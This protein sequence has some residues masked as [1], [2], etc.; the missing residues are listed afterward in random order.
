MT[1][2][3]IVVLS[4]NTKSL[5]VRCIRSIA[6]VYKNLIGKELEV[7]LTDNGSTDQ[8]IDAV[9]NLKLG[10]KIVEN[11]ENLG[12]SKG[13]NK[14][15]KVSL[16]KYLLFLNSDTEIKDEGFFKMADFLDNNPKVGIVGGK[17]L[18]LDGTV[19]K[20]AGSFYNLINLFFVLLGGERIGMIRKSP[21]KAA[22]V[23]WVSGACFMVREDLF[24][25]LKGFD[26]NFFMYMEDME[27]CFRANKFGSLVYY[28]PE[29][30]LLHRER[31]SSNKSFAVNQ[32]YKGLL[33]FYKT[34]KP[35]WQYLL[36]KLLLTLKA[37]IAI[38]V[39]TISNNSDL[40]STYKQALRFAL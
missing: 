25:K 36:V 2:L 8:T 27:L 34:H 31:G 23:D 40:K 10:I 35:Y 26:E 29:I 22:K 1:K 12:F 32:I 13:N 15:A 28:F 33:Y 18:N 19:Q 4:Y 20:S 37:S 16:G 38:I 6:N 39:G 17:L 3:S 30:E 7:I 24:K 14:G 5:T 21:K 11:K 9:K